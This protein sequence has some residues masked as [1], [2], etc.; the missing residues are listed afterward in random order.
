MLNKLKNFEIQKNQNPATESTP[1]INLQK[2]EIAFQKQKDLSK[3]YREIISKIYDTIGS[4]SLEQAFKK[5]DRNKKALL[6]LTYQ[7]DLLD[8]S[9]LF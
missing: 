5:M 2:Q 4:V 8:V 1:N 3:F 9:F 6:E 7:K